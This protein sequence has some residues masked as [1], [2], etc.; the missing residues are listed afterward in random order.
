[1][2]QTQPG[3][4]LIL[5]AMN[6][7]TFTAAVLF[8]LSFPATAQAQAIKSVAEACEE[9][10]GRTVNRVR[11]RDAQQVQFVTAKR[12]LTE[13]SDSETFVKGEGRY[14]RRGGVVPFSYS[15]AVEVKSGQASGVVFR[16]TG[17]GATSIAQTPLAGIASLDPTT[18]ESAAARA[19]TDKH[20][21]AERIVFNPDMRKLRA[22]GDA[23]TGLEGE[24]A[25]ARAPGMYAERFTYS[26]VYNPNG[27]RIDT[28]ST[29][30]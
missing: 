6:V 8:A 29:S 22:V 3:N 25:M 27:N 19:I 7:R 13:L 15:C 26:C 14:S 28:V 23:R 1:M 4:R 24:G 11:G 10:V 2:R 30:D 12:V 20:P 16:E 9:A 5:R 17:D 18:C 21:R